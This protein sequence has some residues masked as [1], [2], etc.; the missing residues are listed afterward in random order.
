[1]PGLAGG[2]DPSQLA[3]LITHPHLDHYGLVDQVASEVPVYAGA[4]AATLV[5]AARFFS[6][7]PALRT[8]GHLEH[9]RPLQLGPFTITPHLVD[10]SGYDAYALVVDAGGQRLMYTGDLRGHGRKFRLFEEMLAAPP[11]GVDTLLLEG[12][13]VPGA[14]AIMRRARAHRAPGRA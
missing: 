9:Q 10:H 6:P 12:T 3:V 5:E 2:K 14:E 7:G 8:D 4:E 11:T 1:V 13:H